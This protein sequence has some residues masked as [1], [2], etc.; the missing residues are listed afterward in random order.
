MNGARRRGGSFMV[1]DED[2][3]LRG[4]VREPAAEALENVTQVLKA[5]RVASL[6]LHPPGGDRVAV[7]RVAGRHTWPG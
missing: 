6:G 7:V 1:A 5:R 4:D 2:H 3:G